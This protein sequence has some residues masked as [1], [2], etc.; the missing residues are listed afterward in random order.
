MDVAK[1]TP[2]P[3]ESVPANRDLVE[4]LFSHGVLTQEARARALSIVNPQTEWAQWAARMLTAVGISLVL[5]GVVY[6]FAYNWEKLTK[7]VKLGSIEL[8]MAACLAGAVYRGLSRPSGQMLLL[9]ASVLVGV[10]WAAFGQVYQTGADAY[11]LFLAWSVMISGFV[12]L[13]NFAPLWVVWLVVTNTFITLYWFQAVVPPP[14]RENQILSI[15]TLFNLAFLALREVFAA[16]GAPWLVNR[17]TRGVLVLT[18]VGLTIG[19][20]VT[21]VLVERPHISISTVQ[22]AALGYGVLAVFFWFY[23]YKAPDMFVLGLAALAVSVVAECGVWRM[24][25]ER[26]GSGDGQEALFVLTVATLALFA[27]LVAALRGLSKGMEATD[28]K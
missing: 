25:R 19:P 4:E 22:A 27:T 8:V 2:T 18:V 17:W 6:F 14:D 26:Y 1:N 3:F 28:G 16:R 21:V 9:C 11:T 24:V 13:S 20:M 5:S 10:F 7:L 12:V 15:L 23:R